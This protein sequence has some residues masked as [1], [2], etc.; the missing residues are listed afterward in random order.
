MGNPQVNALH[1]AA[2]KTN[3]HMSGRFAGMD[4]VVDN[5]G[6]NH[7]S[8][9][10]SKVNYETSNSNSF[11]M[12]NNTNVNPNN[13]VNNNNSNS[14]VREKKDNVRVKED[15]NVS[16]YS[17]D[18]KVMANLGKVKDE[19]ETLFDM[20]TLMIFALIVMVFIFALPFIY[21][22]LG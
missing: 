14:F 18:P 3:S 12:N 9:L 2:K 19:N 16:K 21:N 4:N 22:F 7:P 15:E 13:I 5:Q 10:H 17:N 6:N 1:K 11:L 20:K 8:T